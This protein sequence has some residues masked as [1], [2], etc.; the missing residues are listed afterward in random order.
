MDLV[1]RWRYR[2][3]LFT[4]PILLFSSI[5]GLILKYRLLA[6]KQG[7]FCSAGDDQFII[8]VGGSS[9]AA[10]L[11]FWVWDIKRSARACLDYMPFYFCSPLFIEDKCCNNN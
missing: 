6:E 1:I 11:W 9:G 4:M 7:L 10:Q 2:K 3:L 5:G 8:L